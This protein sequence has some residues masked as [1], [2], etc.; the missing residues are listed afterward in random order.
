LAGFGLRLRA[1]GSRS[2]VFQ[3]ALG[4]KQR[5]MSLGS[6][7]VV[8]LV[9]AREVA[10]EMHAKVRLGHD[11]AGEKEEGRARAADT[12]GSLVDEYLA[13]KKPEMKPRAYAQIERHLLRYAKP[14]HGLQVAKV[15]RHNIAS[16]L[17]KLASTA[18]AVS[19]NRARASLS[20]FYGWAMRGGVKGVNA[21]P[22]LG[23]ERKKEISRDRVLS[24]DE[25][26]AVW[27]AL[28]DDHYGAIVK[29]LI[30]TGQRADEIASLR[31]SEIGEGAITLPPE[32]LKNK[33]G[34][35][36]KPHVVPL[37]GP[38]HAILGTLPRRANGDGTMRELVFG[39]GQRGFSGWSHCKERLDQRLAASG[40][41]LT[42]WTQHD[43]RRSCATGMADLG[44]QPHI[45]EATLNHISGHKA[46]V[47]GIYNRST[48]DAEK[49]QALNL[50]AGHLMAVVEGLGSSVTPMRR[51]A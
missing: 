48:Y 51:P 16:L 22:V 4:E 39:I 46:G 29:L 40:K 2:W 41:A 43:I 17:A 37:S 45:I 20:A 50:W 13:G 25:L 19:S 7:K 33:G 9:K 34:K 5:R 11:P 1:G 15:D 32:R 30:L 42:H 27:N 35:S 24:G 6:A 3:Y 14:L 10:S 8:T 26:A 28:E 38:A 18:G 36:R 47:A 31:W 21:N 23:T 49:R 44:V 12:F